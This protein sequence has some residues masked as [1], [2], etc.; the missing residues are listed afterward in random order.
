M[1]GENGADELGLANED[2]LAGRFDECVARL[3]LL[4]RAQPDNGRA[5]RYLAHVLGLRGE[6]DAAISHYREAIRVDPA[7]TWSRAAMADTLSEKGESEAALVECLTALRLE[8]GS[9]EV[10]M[11]LARTFERMDMCDASLVELDEALR[12]SSAGYERKLAQYIMSGVLFR[13]A[14]L[15]SRRDRWR[16]LRDTWSD[17]RAIT[18]LGPARISEG[19]S[20]WL[21]ARES[22]K[23]FDN[24]YPGDTE[25]LTMLGQTQWEL[26]E[27]EAA[28]ETL[29]RAVD[30]DPADRRIYYYLTGYLLRLGRLKSFWQLFWRG[31]NA[32]TLDPT[33]LLRKKARRWVD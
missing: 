32:G 13:S 3:R 25:V 19:R 26:G 33:Y 24:N 23:E 29:R 17:V 15:S 31:M 9:Y 18:G 7:D 30:I 12:L 10:H 20:Q 28:V 22:L 6:S 11:S 1:S 2:F 14:Y 5:H 16:K 27:R 4:L 8:P 21:E